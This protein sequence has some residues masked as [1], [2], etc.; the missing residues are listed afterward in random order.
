MLKEEQVAELMRRCEALL[1]ITLKKARGSLKSAEAR[2][3][4]IWELLV[5][6]ETS[7]I[8]H[9]EYEPHEG[10]SPDILLTLPSGRKIWIEVAFLYPRYWKQERQSRAVAD[11]ITKE[12]IRRNVSPF[13]VSCQF[14]GDRANDAGPLRVLPELHHKKEFLAGSDVVAFFSAVEKSPTIPVSIRHSEYT[15]SISYSPHATG[16]FL[17]TGGGLVQEAPKTVREHAVYRVLK[18]KAKQHDVNGVRLVCIGSDQSSALSELVSPG[19]PTVRDAVFAAFRETRSL[20]GAIVLRIVDSIRAYGGI[21]RIAKG[22][23][24]LNP[25]ARTKIEEC[26][27]LCL[28][29]L[30]FNRWKYFFRMEKFEPGSYEPFRRVSGGLT[31]SEKNL[32]VTL[33]LPANILIDSLA[34]KTNLKKEYFSDDNNQLLRCL[35]DGWV[36]KSCSLKAGNVEKGEAPKVILELEPPPEAVF[37]PLSKK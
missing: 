5:L 29:R 27:L 16:P 6:E 32:G 36:V 8:G 22:D 10:G 13:K 23:I 33:E 4:A 31:M 3:A 34:G 1:G 26:D 15:V 28:Q 37:W 18:G 17:S 21:D 7:R 2:S 35:D 20:S 24:F 11:W 19:N 25:S 9:V 30:D 14:D 12:S